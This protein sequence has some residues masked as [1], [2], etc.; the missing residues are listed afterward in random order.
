[1]ISDIASGHVSIKYG[2]KGPN[3]CVV[4][5]CSTAS[6]SIGDAFRMIC[7][8]D[9]DVIVTGGSDATIT[10]MA[11]AGFSGSSFVVRAFILVKPATAMGVIVASDPPVTITSAS[12]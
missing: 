3:Y 6:H 1:M 2:L 4:S 8:G 9:A 7:Y 5:A 12:P 10:P 11:V